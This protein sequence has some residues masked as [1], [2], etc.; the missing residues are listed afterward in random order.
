MMIGAV[1]VAAGRSERFGEDKLQL[2]LGN[3][4]LWKW[5]FDTLASHPRISH[6]VIVARD[7]C[8]NA[9]DV[10]G[11]LVVGGGSTRTESVRNGLAALPATATFSLIHDAARPFLSHALIDTL[12]QALPGSSGAVIPALPLTDTIRQRGQDGT[13]VVDRDSLFAAQTPQGARHAL[14]L[15]AFDSNGGAATDDAAVVEAL[16]YPTTVVPGDQ[17]NFKITTSADYD[18]AN[19]M[20]SPA[21]TRTGFGYDIHRFSDDP[22]RRLMLGGVTHDGPGLEGHSDADAL[23]HA[24]VDALLGASGGGDIGILYP[25]TDPTWKDADSLRF[26]S[27]TADRLRG[28]GWTIVNID[29]TILAERPR[30]RPRYD[31][32]RQ[33][34]AVAAGI[35][36]ERINVKATTHEGL[37]SIGRAEGIAA[38][39]VATIA[40]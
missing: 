34:M 29:A 39:A 31:D 21:E 12:L 35:D 7:G 38:H 13:A 40:R 25:N 10:P 24:V 33:A 26:L 20:L 1:I 27:E 28:E 32:M 14:W 23:V 2:K 17:N 16:G 19:R 22:S 8:Q 37:G 9:F 30:L 4:P 18:R 11:A 6:V 36:V 5:S 15:E 3:K